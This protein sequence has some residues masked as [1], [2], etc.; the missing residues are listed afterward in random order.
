MKSPAGVVGQ[1][2]AGIC[3]FVG[4]IIV[5]DHMDFLISGHL[6]F[7]LVKKAQ[8]LLMPVSCP[9]PWWLR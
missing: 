9:T 2:G 4:A 7:N 5:E 8:K 1:P 3:V 6:T